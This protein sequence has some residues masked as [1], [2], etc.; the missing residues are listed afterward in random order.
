MSSRKLN[1]GPETNEIMSASRHS[2]DPGE[3]RA[4]FAEAARAENVSE[5]PGRYMLIT[6]LERTLV[7]LRYLAA[8]VHALEAQ[9]DADHEKT[10][11]LASSS[12]YAACTAV[13]MS[14]AVLQPPVDNERPL[15][16]PAASAFHQS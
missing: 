16:R 2:D 6:R 7:D 3:P 15:R 13:Q 9:A 1:A 10:R 8:D 11:S 4:L 12:I 5:L 14:L